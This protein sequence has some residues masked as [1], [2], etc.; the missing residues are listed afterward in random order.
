MLA[1]VT[2]INA[3]ITEFWFPVRV[4]NKIINASRPYFPLNSTT[5][6][7]FI[8]YFPLNS[9]T[10]IFFYQNKKR[11]M[12]FCGEKAIRLQGC[13]PAG[14]LLRGSLRSELEMEGFKVHFHF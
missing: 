8:T 10:S 4:Q 13:V 6:I 3:D 9:T 7:F 5:S 1:Y 14:F 11:K 2:Y 12:V